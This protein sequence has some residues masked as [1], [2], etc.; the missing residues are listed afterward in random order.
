M[1]TIKCAS[2]Y[3]S[4][5]RR[6]SIILHTFSLTQ[7]WPLTWTKLELWNTNGTCIWAEGNFCLLLSRFQQWHTIFRGGP[8]RCL[9]K[10][11]QNDRP[12]IK[13]RLHQQCQPIQ[14]KLEHQAKQ[15]TIPHGWA[16]WVWGIEKPGGYGLC[17]YPR[18]YCWKYHKLWE[19]KSHANFDR[20]DTGIPRTD[21]RVLT[22]LMTPGSIYVLQQMVKSMWCEKSCAPWWPEFLSIS[23]QWLAV[24][25]TRY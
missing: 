17:P 18:G 25:K 8:Y 11:T 2:S 20:G 5:I 22:G 24:A 4:A 1:S 16:N 23:V 9:G 10:R 14:L 15:R 3:E 19:K 7:R 13:F 21:H 6:L 12:S